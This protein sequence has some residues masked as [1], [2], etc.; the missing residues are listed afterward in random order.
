MKKLF[1][2]GF[3]LGILL[4]GAFFWRRSHEL[5]SV[6]F[7]KPRTIQDVEKLFTNNVAH[8][9]KLVGKFR[10]ELPARVQSIL[11]V[12]SAKRTFNNTARALDSINVYDQ[13]IIHT[14]YILE[15]LS[16]DQTVR[17][18]A[19]A[20]LLE[21][22]LLVQKHVFRNKALF[23]VLKDYAD[24]HAPQE[25][26]S[27]QERYYLGE[28]VRLFMRNGLML[29]DAQ[30]ERV[31]ALNEELAKLIARFDANFDNITQTLAFTA[32]ELDGVPPM[33]LA[34]LGTDRSG[35][36]SIGFDYPTVDAILAH[37][38]DERVRERVYKAFENRAYPA[39][40]EILQEIIAKRAELARL[41]GFENYAQYDLANQMA[42]TQNGA[43][44]FI[45]RVTPHARA[46]Q[47][48]EFKALTEVLPPSV[49]L[50][51]GKAKPWD[52]AYLK[53]Q[54]AQRKL[55]LDSSL[56]AQ[57][58]PVT[59]VINETFALFGE[60]LGLQFEKLERVHFWHESVMCYAV[61]GVQ[62][63]ALRGYLLLDLFPR[64]NKYTWA[65][66]DDVVP[67]H[68]ASDGSRVPAVVI[69]IANITPPARG[70]P[71][72]LPFAD[73]VTF[74][75]EFGHAAHELVVA[76]PL[77]SLC[78]SDANLDFGETPS[79]LFEQWIYD[80]T[81][82]RRI[83]RHYKT[84]QPLPEDMVDALA[85]TERL[86]IGDDTTKRLAFSDLGLTLY[87][88]Y[89]G[90]AR[91]LCKKILTN[92]CS[93]LW[94]DDNLCPLAGWVHAVEYGAKFYSYL[95]SKANAIDLFAYIKKNGLTNLQ[96]GKRLVETVLSPCGSAD[97][98]KLMTDFLGRTPNEK[99]YIAYLSASS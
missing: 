88:G 3:C 52:L 7:A 70:Y 81:I 21:V 97:P 92:Y 1:F 36:Y 50:V 32:K 25:R 76:T 35:S 98:L 42:R 23:L 12:P 41:L 73:L 65:E 78:G 79:Q 61:Y 68:I 44:A 26:L 48:R 20:A 56:V 54:Y 67:P 37:A 89:E 74:F 96:T 27:D 6:D 46:K 77:P 9:N 72:L 14:F 34:G 71:G 83:G 13:I 95:W 33:V 17:T 29:S 43:R 60:F 91:Q 93:Y 18:R 82:I 15:R 39:N 99:A 28:V 58:F 53:E 4:A 30:L 45:E 10:R 2:V 90:D 85:Q 80:P 51:N 49:A 11:D 94:F 38:R 19:R 64:S 16:P 57:Y 22:Q 66:M 24:H 40:Y 86:Q 75:H 5:V 55:A 84:G 47:A 87:S 31:C 62:D 63:R 8:I 59:R 69:I